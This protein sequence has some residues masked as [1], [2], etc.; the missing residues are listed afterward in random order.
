[1]SDHHWQ[2]QQV[3]ASDAGAQLREDNDDEVEFG[4]HFVILPVGKA[5]TITRL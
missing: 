1:V 2:Q 5:F 3:H 4:D